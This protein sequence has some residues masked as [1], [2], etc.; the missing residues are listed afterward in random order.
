MT[1]DFPLD[2]RVPFTFRVVYDVQ[3]PLRRSK[4]LFGICFS[5]FSPAAPKSVVI[6]QGFI[7]FGRRFQG[8]G[9]G[10]FIWPGI[11]PSFSSGP[12]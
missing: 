11:I 8:S 3:C 5:R 12:G 2:D 6:V 7:N 4:I 1:L 9:P 10:Y